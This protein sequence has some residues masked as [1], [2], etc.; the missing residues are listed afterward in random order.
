MIILAYLFYRLVYINPK[1]Q[2]MIEKA[3]DSK[4]TEEDKNKAG[5]KYYKEEIEKVKRE[6]VLSDFKEE[7][8]DL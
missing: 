2:K 3:V 6:D 8:D 1:F 5:Y 4:Q 7:F